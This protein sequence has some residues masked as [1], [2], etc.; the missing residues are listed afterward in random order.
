VLLLPL[1]VAFP[2]HLT[3]SQLTRTT[4]ASPVDFVIQNVISAHHNAMLDT[5][6]SAQLE[7]AWAAKSHEDQFQT[8]LRLLR[9]VGKYEGRFQVLR[10]DVLKRVLSHADKILACDAP[11]VINV[12]N[13]VVDSELTRRPELR[14]QFMAVVASG[15]N[16]GCAD[17]EQL[18]TPPAAAVSQAHV[19]QSAQ[20]SLMELI[21]CAQR[22]AFK[23]VLAQILA[24][25]QTMAVI[26]VGHFV[27]CRLCVYFL[28]SYVG[29]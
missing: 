24:Q 6:N 16:A 28:F 9:A 3:L 5:L 10:K 17:V 18:A 23:T 7:Q 14:E 26:D 19:L 1:C 2:V 20:T 25:L 27:W 12:A 22:R 4:G 13:R 15:A 8:S 11:A 29:M 21:N